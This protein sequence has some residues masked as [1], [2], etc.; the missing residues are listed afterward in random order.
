MVVELLPSGVVG[1]NTRVWEV[2]AAQVGGKS[3]DEWYDLP[4]E[5]R[6]AKVASVVVPGWLSELNARYAV[7]RRV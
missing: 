6:N 2:Q 4:F 5:E 3:I 1:H 7:A